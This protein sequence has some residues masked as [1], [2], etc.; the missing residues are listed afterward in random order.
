[1]RAKQWTTIALLQETR[2]Y[3]ES[4]GIE[5]PRLDAELLLAHALGRERIRLYL[6]FEQ[7]LTPDEVSG[8][9]ELVRRRAQRE[10]VAYITGHREFWSLRLTVNRSVLI[11]RPETESLVE[12]SLALL[13]EHLPPGAAPMVLDLGTGSGAIA[14]AL[15]KEIEGAVIVAADRSLPALRVANQNITAHGVQDRVHL[16]CS[17]WGDMLTGRSLFDLIVANPPYIPTAE[18]ETLAPEIKNHEPHEAL[19]GGPDG[20]D[21][22]RTWIP[23]LPRLLRPGGW[24]ALEIGD[25]QSHTVTTICTESGCLKNMGIKKD[26]ANVERVITAQKV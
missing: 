22:Y 9:R 16:V 12:A 26:Y 24:I 13:R 3:F 8:F 7:P 21:F 1:M 20:L 15:A 23:L 2:R 6:D 19:D 4:C 17:D 5:S 10:P 25:G 14:I 11:P 18:I